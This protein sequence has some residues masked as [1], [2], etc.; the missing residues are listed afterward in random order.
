MISILSVRI[1]LEA[2]SAAF[3]GS[4]AVST[5]FSLRGSFFPASLI[6]IPPCLLISPMASS[7]AQGEASPNEAMGPVEGFG[8]PIRMKSRFAARAGLAT[9]LSPP[10]RATAAPT[11]PAFF[12][13]S[14]RL[15][16]FLSDIA[17][18]FWVYFF[19]NLKD[20]FCLLHQSGRSCQQK[21]GA[22]Q[23]RFFLDI[24]F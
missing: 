16:F 6:K 23:Q 24:Y 9:A 13:N 15:I 21:N 22:W 1:S 18:S 20:A 4:L 7:S 2:T 10:V 14:L 5:N 19:R 12:I 3:V 17:P 8:C 11:L